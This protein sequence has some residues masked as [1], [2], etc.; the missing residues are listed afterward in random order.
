MRPI[1]R[2]ENPLD[3]AGNPKVFT[4]HKY[5]RGD[6]IDRLGEYCSYCEM[7]VHTALAVEHIKPKAKDLYPEL[8]LEWDNFLLACPNCNSNKG[9]KDVIL[10][11]YYWSHIDNTFRAFIYSEGGLVKPHPLLTDEEKIKAKAT[12]ELVALQKHSVNDGERRDRRQSNRR[13]TWDMAKRAL[14]ILQSKNIPEMREQIVDQSKAS[15]FWSVWMTVFKD[16]PDMLQR[17]IDAFAGTCR[18]CFDI[19]GNPIPR[20]K[21]QL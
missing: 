3:S 19:S 18:D 12:L 21:G 7:P 2:G 14:S 15:G 16:D 20:Q 6:L 13:E 9:H 10:E 1:L 17:F 5:A 11:D 4:R 8:E